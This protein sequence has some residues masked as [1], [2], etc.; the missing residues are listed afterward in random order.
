MPERNVIV[1]HTQSLLALK[2]AP[3]TG[4]EKKAQHPLHKLIPP[5]TKGYQGHNLNNRIK[6]F[7]IIYLNFTCAKL[8]TECLL[9]ISDEKLGGFIV[10]TL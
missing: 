5:Q 1:A 10:L 3:K 8:A 2:S 6:L 9:R 4:S 7:E